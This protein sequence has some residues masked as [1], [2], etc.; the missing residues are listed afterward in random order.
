MRDDI[1]RKRYCVGGVF[2]I[3]SLTLVGCNPHIEQFEQTATPTQV[4]SNETLRHHN[5]LWQVAGQANAPKKVQPYVADHHVL[6][7]DAKK[8]VGRYSVI[9]QCTDPIARCGDEKEDAVEFI[10]NLMPDGSLYRLIKRLGTIQVDSRAS[11]NYFKDHWELQRI[12][13]QQYLIVSYSSNGMKFFYRIDERGGLLM[14][15]GR[16]KLTNLQAYR[17][18]YPFP[19][20]AYTLKKVIE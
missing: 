16:N 2:A 3:L 12:N 10:L 19:N 1:Q 8:I 7:E 18:G 11:P 15:L 14:D 20:H 9:I 5:N 13:D 17:K 6:S 4:E